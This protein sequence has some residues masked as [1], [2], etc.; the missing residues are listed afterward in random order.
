MPT[1]KKNQKKNNRSS[2][3]PT[4]SLTG[5]FIILLLSV[6]GIQ[7]SP[8]VKELFGLSTNDT[9]QSTMQQSSSSTQ[10]S[11][12]VSV[13]PGP[14]SHGKATFT[15]RELDDASNGWINYHSLD[16]LERATGADALLKQSMIGTGTSANSSIRPPGFISGKDPYGHSRGHLI[17]KQLGGSGDDERN[18]VTLYQ[19]PVNS[20]YM[21]KYENQIRAALDKG[22]T[23][24][25]RVTP[26]YT[27]TQL[28]CKE[29][30]MEA[31]SLESNGSVNFNVVIENTK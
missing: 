18:I 8:E 5:I 15:A 30:H 23:V 1:K 17:G 31:Q 11:S 25:Y 21:T 16:S 9:S 20:P 6:I 7:V 24:R 19:T 22:E 10:K 12:E 4:K 26:I 3:S 28:M 29:V 27:G 13:N 2:F 14:I